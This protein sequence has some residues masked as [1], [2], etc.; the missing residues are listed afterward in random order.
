MA[1]RQKLDYSVRQAIVK[2]HKEKFTIRE[3]SEKVKRSK[4][5]V[6]RVVKSYNDTGKV[7]AFKTGR[8]LKNSAREDR[9]MQP[10]SV[11]GHF[12]SCTEIKRVMN[13]TSCVNVSRQT[14]SRRLQEIGLFN[15]TPRKKPLVSSKN[16]KKRLEFANRYVIW[17]YENWAKVFF[18]DESKFN[19]FG[20][21]GKKCKET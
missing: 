1:K 10:M 20:N 21:D 12:K 3:I 4:S 11:K 13:S 18:S 9:I 8:P 16:K 6:G 7:S 15:R 2:L 17:T 14:V 5:V 19:L